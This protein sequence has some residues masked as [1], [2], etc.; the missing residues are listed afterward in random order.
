MTLTFC[1]SIHLEFI[2]DYGMR[3]VSF[4]SNVCPLFFQSS[5][6]EMILEITLSLIWSC[7]MEY[8]L[9]FF[10]HKWAYFLGSVLFLWSF[11]LLL[12]FIFFCLFF[13]KNHWK[14]FLTEVPSLP[15][16][17]ASWGRRHTLAPGEVKVGGAV[18]WSFAV[19]WVVFRG[20]ET[21][22]KGKEMHVSG[23]VRVRWRGDLDL[24]G[25]QEFSLSREDRTLERASSTCRRTGEVLDLGAEE[26]AQKL[27]VEW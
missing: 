16:L 2:F 22:R 23:R 11:L 24:N 13:K 14:W 20:P 25:G 3:Y 19:L 21:V 8:I 9:Y 18:R 6:F 17:K 15:V 26:T 5:F 7:L 4:V 10:I 1:S 12:L 27:W